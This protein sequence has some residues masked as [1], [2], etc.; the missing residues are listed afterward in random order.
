MV[1][2]GFQ[3]KSEKYGVVDISEVITSSDF[4]KNQKENLRTVGQTRQD[5]LQFANTY[6]LFT[7]EQAQKFR[8]LSIKP[9]PTAADKAELEKLKNDVI[10]THKKFQDL[11]LKANPTTEQVTLLRDYNE[12]SQT[13]VKTLD[14]WAREFSDEIQTL[15]DKLRQETMNRATD[16]VKEVGQKQGYSVVYMQD[17]VPYA[18]NNITADALKAMNSK[19]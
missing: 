18:A 10:A 15:Q 1:G 3:T 12:R 2:S 19:K 8:D 4:A 17:V 13:M 6:P 11:Q 14:R 9:Q 5:L 7:P 16:A